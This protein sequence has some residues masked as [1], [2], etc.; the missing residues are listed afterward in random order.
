M[1]EFL[2]LH[3]QMIIDNKVKLVN[4]FRKL[5]SGDYV[6]VD[7]SCHRHDLTFF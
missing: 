4:K 5:Q 3:F 1:V 2:S 7:A 6:V